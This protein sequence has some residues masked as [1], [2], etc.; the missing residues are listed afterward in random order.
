MKWIVVSS[1]AIGISLCAVMINIIERNILL[2]IGTFLVL[3]LNILM[4]Y[5][6]ILRYKGSK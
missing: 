6:N 5:T 3:V 2:G 1:I 4:L